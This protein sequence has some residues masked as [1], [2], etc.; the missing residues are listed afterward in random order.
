MVRAGTVV[1]MR[2]GGRGGRRDDG[3]GGM[4][5]RG[6]ARSIVVAGRGVAMAMESSRSGEGLLSGGM[7]VR[8][9]HPALAGRAK[10]GGGYCASDREH[11]REEQQQRYANGPD[12]DA[13]EEW[14]AWH[15]SNVRP[16]ASE[17][18]TL[19]PELQARRQRG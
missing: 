18:N 3:C 11:Q 5:S 16:L 8:G 4:M 17:A 2:A 7:M 12:D 13:P 1:G 10:H 14:R 6:L 9:G 19:S 15:E